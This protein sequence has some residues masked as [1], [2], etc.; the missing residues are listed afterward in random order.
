MEL[1]IL[2]SCEIGSTRVRKSRE[3]LDGHRRI[4]GS[5]KAMCPL[6]PNPPWHRSTPPR[7][8][9]TWRILPPPGSG[10]IRWPS[11]TVRRVDLPVELP[12]HESGS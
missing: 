11:G 2:V 10:K 1:T 9:M 12:L 6:I 5:L 8:S 3:R 4:G 7:S